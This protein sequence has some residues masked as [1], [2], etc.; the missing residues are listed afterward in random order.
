MRTKKMI[1]DN[2]SVRIT[3]PIEKQDHNWS[4]IMARTEAAEK[5]AARL[6]KK[7]RYWWS[8]QTTKP[9][10]LVVTA[11]NKVMDKMEMTFLIDLTQ[12]GLSLI[13]I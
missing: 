8:K 1:T 10:I 13:H 12:L 4:D 7:L 11:G 6:Q 5:E 2:L 9:F 3:V